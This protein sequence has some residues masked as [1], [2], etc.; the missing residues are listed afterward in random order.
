VSPTFDIE[1]MVVSFR[2]SCR[3]LAETKAH[4]REFAYI[5]GSAKALRKRAATSVEVFFLA[6]ARPDENS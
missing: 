5:P 6:A 3:C 2:G 1:Y 4:I